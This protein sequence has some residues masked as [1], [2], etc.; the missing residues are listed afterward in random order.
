VQ[1]GLTNA[2][3]HAPDAPATVT[4]HRDNGGGVRVTVHNGHGVR[5]PM[6]LPSSGAG[7]V[8]LAERIRLVGGSMRSGPLDDGWELYA[9]VPRMDTP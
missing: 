5:A 7:L 3:K 9:V 8:G 1:E 4:V 6:D 2:R